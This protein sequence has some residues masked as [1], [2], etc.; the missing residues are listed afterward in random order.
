MSIVRQ[1][2]IGLVW[3]YEYSETEDGAR[4]IVDAVANGPYDVLKAQKP[5][6]G[7]PMPGNAL[8]EV[9]KTVLRKVKGGNGRLEVTGERG[10]EI[11]IVNIART[12]EIEI[13]W[14]RYERALIRHP[15]FEYP[16]GVWALPLDA[17]A[18]INA[19]EG[20]SNVVLR[21][22]L[23][24]REDPEDDVSQAKLLSDLP[25]GATGAV[26]YATRRLK[27]V[28]SFVV[29]APVIRRN[30]EYGHAP[31]E[32]SS[33]DCNNIFAASDLASRLGIPIPTG[34]GSPWKYMKTGDNWSR[35]QPRGRF[36]RSEEWTGA[37]DWDTELYPVPGRP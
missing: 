7:S 15:K 10:N 22:G 25:N 37:D 28:E 12:L 2:N 31:S 30:W 24:Y 3:S 29:F 18:A 21:G 16:S 34:T 6:L 8:Y 33:T 36:R 19:W 9:V 11:S 20:E 13:D 23:S 17:H 14:V 4:E 5:A 26:A 1:G 35:S 32:L 27:G